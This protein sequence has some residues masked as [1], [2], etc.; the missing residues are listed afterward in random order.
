MIPSGP[1][2]VGTFQAAT[3][4]GLSLFI[5]SEVIDTRGTAYANVLWAVQLAF[6]TALGMFFLFSRHIRFAQIF[7]APREVEEGLE[8]EERQYVADG[9]GGVAS[10]RCRALTGQ[11]VGPISAPSEREPVR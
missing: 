6:T 10:G 9:D 11:V 1:G 5:P 3:I 8:E 7:S 2:M 4:L